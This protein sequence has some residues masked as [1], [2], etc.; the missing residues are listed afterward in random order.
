MVSDFKD[1]LIRTQFV[2]VG[3]ECK[4]IERKE[5]KESSAATDYLGFDGFHGYNGLLLSDTLTVCQNIEIGFF[6]LV[7]CCSVEV[8]QNVY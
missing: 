1:I 2:L 3:F 4:L 8:F 7:A 6:E 5:Y